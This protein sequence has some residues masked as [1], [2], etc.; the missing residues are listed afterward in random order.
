MCVGFLL[1]LLLLLLLFWQESFE[2][3]RKKVAI[4]F[5]CH[6]FTFF[7]D[8]FYKGLAGTIVFVWKKNPV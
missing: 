5:L 7:S 8:I 1:S 4:L 2:A 3:V 6:I